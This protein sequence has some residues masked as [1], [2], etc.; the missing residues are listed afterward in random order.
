MDEWMKGW[1]DGWMERKNGW[2]VRGKPK[3]PTIWRL[4]MLFVV[5]FGLCRQQ[6]PQQS[7]GKDRLQSIPTKPAIHVSTFTYLNIH[8]CGSVFVQNKRSR[9]RTM[10]ATVAALARNDQKPKPFMIIRSCTGRAVGAVP[11]Q[12]RRW[13]TLG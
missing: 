9:S 3:E 13:K 4:A 2:M 6:G 11:P 1:M 10:L 12:K 5:P 7:A 8:I